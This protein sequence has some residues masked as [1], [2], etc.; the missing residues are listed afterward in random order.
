MFSLTATSFEVLSPASRLLRGA[1]EKS[2]VNACVNTYE[3]SV[4]KRVDT[5]SPG[6]QSRSAAA[7]GARRPTRV[8]GLQMRGISLGKSLTAIHRLGFACSML[9]LRNPAC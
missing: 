1:F 4:G 5:R 6:K 3:Q 7:G 8:I 9:W 2:L